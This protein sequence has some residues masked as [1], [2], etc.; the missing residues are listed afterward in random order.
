M[1]KT[2]IIDRLEQARIMA[3]PLR[4]RLL[5]AFC[6]ETMTT[7]QAAVALGLPP[8]K[9]YHHVAALERVGLVR[10][11][12]TRKKRGTTEKY[13]QTVAHRFVVDRRLFEVSAAA[14]ETLNGL[15]AISASWLEDTAAE[16]KQSIADKL[17]QPG[18]RD[19]RA[20]LARLHIS[21]TPERFALLQRKLEA[22]LAEFDAAQ[23]QSGTIHYGLTVALYPVK[24]PKARGRG[25]LPAG[26]TGKEKK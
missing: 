7:M 24:K 10:L 5:E 19:K 15:N 4:M 23:G 12:R 17:I 16:L 2:W 25:D 8:T 6:R 9:L 14:E 1:K 26:R 11:V 22:L 18:N 3:H 13:Y 20:L 21:T